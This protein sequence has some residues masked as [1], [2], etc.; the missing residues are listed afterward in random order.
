MRTPYLR[1]AEFLAVSV[2]KSKCRAKIDVK[3]KMT[4][5]VSSLIS[6]SDEICSEQQ[7]QPSNY[8]RLFNDKIFEGTYLF[9]FYITGL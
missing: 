2:I 7:A 5:A 6:R 3:Q 8:L 4:V 9:T 1:E